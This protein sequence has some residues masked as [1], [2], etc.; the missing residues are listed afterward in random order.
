MLGRRAD[1]G[2]PVAL[3]P[4]SAGRYVLVDPADDTRIPVDGKLARTLAA[5]RGRLLPDALLRPCQPSAGSS[6]SPCP[7]S[8]ASSGRWS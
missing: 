8:G 3:I 2:R 7:R 6:A 5:D 4:G 1:D